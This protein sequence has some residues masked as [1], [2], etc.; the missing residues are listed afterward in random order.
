MLCRN[1][2]CWAGGGGNPS[3]S[4]TPTFSRRSVYGSRLDFGHSSYVTLPN[5]ALECENGPVIPPAGAIAKPWF[6]ILDCGNTAE[7][8]PPFIPIWVF[9]VKNSCLRVISGASDGF[10]VCP[11]NN[12]SYL[13]TALFVLFYSFCGLVGATWRIRDFLW[14]CQPQHCSD[15]ITASTGPAHCMMVG[16]CCQIK[17]LKP[18]AAVLLTT[19]VGFETRP[20]LFKEQRMMRANRGRYSCW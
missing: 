8:C 5:P 3:E 18:L 16:G 13:S 10:P 14:K 11:H 1:S 6:E 4:D 9:S 19:C 20:P 12:C 2:N 17:S 7:K 15:W